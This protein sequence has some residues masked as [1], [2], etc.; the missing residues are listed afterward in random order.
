MQCAH[1][2]TPV[3][4][5]ARFCHS[6]GSLVSDAEGQ[7]RASGAM[8]Q[9]SFD[10]IEELLRKETEGDYQIQRLLGKGGMAVVYLAREVHLARNV[11]IKVLPPEL[12]FGHGVERFKREAKTAAALDH[13]NIIPIYRVSTGGTLFWYA[14]KFLE[15]ESLEQLLKD[16]GRLPLDLTLKILRQVGEAL[17]YAHEHQV[18]HRDMKPANVMLDSRMR[19]IVTDFGIAKALT[20]GTLT[21]SGSVI[22]T[23]YFMSPE[24]G[25]GKVV[26]GASD[27]YSVGVMAYRMLAGHVP[28]E[29][30]SAIDVLHKH[31]MVQPPPL[32]TAAPGLPRHVYLAVHRSLDKKPENRFPTVGE[33]VAA[34]EQD[35][36]L[37]AS[38]PAISLG[39]TGAGDATLVVPAQGMASHDL[40][41]TPMPSLAGSMPGV[42]PSDA[43]MATPPTPR[44][45][46]PRPMPPRPVPKKK[47]TPI[48]AIAAAVIVLGGGAAGAWYFL[49]RQ[50]Q[51]GPAGSIEPVVQTGPTTQPPTEVPPAAP[52]ETTV[53]APVQQPV[54]QQP[55]PAETAPARPAAPAA[56]RT[57]TLLVVGLPAGGTVLLADGRVIREPTVQLPPGRHQLTLAATGFQPQ[58]ETVTIVAG[59]TERVTWRQVPIQVSAPPVQ[60]AVEPPSVPTRPAGLGEGMGV[61][62]LSISNA[63]AEVFFDGESKGTQRRFVTTTIAGGHSLRLVASGFATLDTL[64]QVPEK[65]TARVRVTLRAQ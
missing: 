2:A 8:T 47:G 30:S 18:V 46:P 62:M 54:A 60:Q 21:A 29:G 44:T 32:E 1:C 26:T 36:G 34:L 37:S 59:R 12:T 13:P 64:I 52:P 11:A 4:D 9:D 27:Q 51:P 23:P 43:T 15:G 5:D 28:F 22:G 41:T 45:I 49:G 14:M 20:E 53:T 48:G 39:G 55:T 25:M 42:A 10:K 61:L 58:D 40:A 56:P 38:S 6:C 65:D 17:D 35:H 50:P 33:F 24:Q 3:P 31:C 7:A 16:R 57:G 63:T 19:V